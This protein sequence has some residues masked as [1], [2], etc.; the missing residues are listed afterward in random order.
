VSAVSGIPLQILPCFVFCPSATD[1][2]QGTH[3][4]EKIV[5][6]L[7]N[8]KPEN[9]DIKIKIVDTSQ[10]IQEV[11]LL[12]L[13]D[14]DDLRSRLEKE[15][16]ERAK[17]TADLRDRLDKETKDLR[18]RLN[19]EI[20]DREADR[21]R[22]QDNINKNA[23]N[24]DEGMNDLREMLKQERD[25]RIDQAG[26]MDKFFNDENDARKKN[27]DDVNNWIQV[28]NDKRQ[29]E[30]EALR[31]RMEREKKELQEFIDKDNKKMADRIAA[32]NAERQ[33][34]EQEL[35]DR[36]KEAQEASENG[37][38]QL[39][40][41]MQAEN[42]AR[43][44]EIAELRAKLEREKAELAEK[45][46]KEKAEMKEKLEKENQQLRDKL[47]EEKQGLKGS[48]D[49]NHNHANKRINDLAEKLAKQMK[50]G[51]QGINDLTDKMIK[52]HALLRHLMS[53]PLSVYFDAFRTEDYVDGGEEYLTFSGTK[54]NLGSAMDPK[55]GTFTAPLD[56]S[57][58]FTIHVC[59]HDMKKGLL[60]IRCNG[61]ELASFYD[62]NHDSNHKNSMASQS[63]IAELCEGDKI[64]IYMYTHT[65]LQDKKSNWLTHFVGV[66]LRPKNFLVDPD[67]GSESGSAISNGHAE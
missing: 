6:N 50:E 10:K 53:Q 42:L 38:I 43:E 19:K 12:L 65:G 17:E 60:S 25:E 15:A 35:K 54:C 22:L 26:K 49:G 56:G 29:K 64:Q 41:K 30:A 18:D 62:Q 2:R 36:M 51:S 34:K 9:E 55:S 23:K 13:S 67:T 39:Y 59:T 48:I 21:D 11:L 14:N 8:M 32:E 63:I 5:Q 28:E 20:A 52:E 27:L 3:L 57:Y 4:V 7:V 61:N 31:E 1:D 66:F 44:A 40:K 33:K 16:A 37:T 24:G 58:S 45:M 46:E 47:A